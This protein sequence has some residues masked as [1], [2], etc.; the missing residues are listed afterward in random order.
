[1][2]GLLMNLI[3]MILV[4]LVTRLPCGRALNAV[5]LYSILVGLRTVLIRPPFR[6]AP[7][8][9]PLFMVVLITVN[10]AAGRRIICIFSS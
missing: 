5:R 6:G 9:A 10:S 7:T 8:L 3:P 2:I 4:S 1:M